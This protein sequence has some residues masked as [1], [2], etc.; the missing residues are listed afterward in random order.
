[1]INIQNYKGLLYKHHQIQSVDMA[2]FDKNFMISMNG[3]TNMNEPIV[4]EQ[5]Q[6]MIP[7]LNG[8]G[9]DNVPKFS[10]PDK[11]D[12]NVSELVNGDPKPKKIPL[13]NYKDPVS[14]LDYA[15][16]FTK[17]Y[18]PLMS[19]RGD[20]PLRINEYPGTGTDAFTSKQLAERV[21]SAS[22]LDPALL[23]AS[24]MEEGMSGLYPSKDNTVNFSGNKE[25]PISGYINFGLDTFSDAF[26]NL[27]KKGYLPEDFNK[28]FVK[29]VHP[30]KE[31]D[32]KVAVNSADF[33]SLESAL[34]AKAAMI[35]NT[36]DE[37]GSFLD[38]NKIALS[39]KARQFFNLVA[40]NAGIGNA[41]K[42]LKDYKQAGVL[43]DD[44]FLNERPKK[45]AGLKE[46]SWSQPYEN[47]IRRIKM[48]EALKNEGYFDDQEE[49][50]TQQGASKKLT[51]STK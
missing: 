26:L 12:K 5:T 3:L 31:G 29:K 24:A 39:D 2:R 8:S 43:Q 10:L 41:Q 51:Q 6:D 11:A 47:A 30:P 50:A 19:G 28:N 34:Q 44:A 16:Q 13:P 14:R 9:Q 32:N 48:S 36:Q 46:T 27:V 1:M 49:M 22:G 35:R 21:G 45:G 20:T 18:G 23:Y 25:F 4:E 42:M 7:M 33:K 37:L 40:Y 17:K 38:E 15:K